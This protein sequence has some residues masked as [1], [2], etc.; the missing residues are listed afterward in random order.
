MTTVILDRFKSDQN[1]TFGT[2]SLNGIQ[3]AYTCELPWKNNQ[4]NISCIP[5]GTYNCIN[6]SS[7]KFPDVWQICNVPD[8]GSIL[9]HNGNE[10]DDLHGCICVG[11][12]LGTVNDLPAV[13]NSVKTLTALKSQL[14]DIFTLVINDPKV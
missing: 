12:S 10:I 6:Y 9:I 4:P 3:I 8:R 1:G 13:L 2:L 7:P 14:P 11:D 5:A